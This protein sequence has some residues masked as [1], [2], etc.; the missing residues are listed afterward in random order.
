MHVHR[1]SFSIHAPCHLQLHLSDLALPFIHPQ[2]S[3]GPCFFI[4]EGFNVR[5]IRS[6]VSFIYAYDAV[7]PCA[8]C[9]PAQTQISRDE[10]NNLPA[11][12]LLEVALRCSHI[13]VDAP[14]RRHLTATSPP[15]TPP[16]DRERTRDATLRD[17]GSWRERQ[18]APA[19]EKPM[20]AWG[21]VF[22]V[23][24]MRLLPKPE[25]INGATQD[26]QADAADPFAP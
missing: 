12:Q 16:P 20:P 13:Y 14:P 22:V 9:F 5:P 26:T 24:Y 7:L 11:G 1:L 6:I 15:N 3:C 25:P 18:R 8:T 10:Y 21:V 19:T 23:E 17:V 2:Q 4:Q